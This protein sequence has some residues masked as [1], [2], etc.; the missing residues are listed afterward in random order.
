MTFKSSELAFEGDRVR[1]ARGTLTILGIPKPVTFEIAYFKCGSHPMLMRKVCGADMTATIKRS[2][3]GM[4]YLLP[5]LGDEVLL[6]VNV[7]AI[8]DS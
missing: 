8:K 2:D 5:T 4:K 6:R 7:E 3:Y 1:Q